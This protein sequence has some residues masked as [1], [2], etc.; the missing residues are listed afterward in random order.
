MPSPDRLV[1]YL[2]LAAADEAQVRRVMPR[3]EDALR[4]ATLPDAGT[5]LL[6]VRKLA[7]GRIAGGATSQTL[8]R[9]IEQRVAEAG[10]QWVDGGATAAEGAAFVSFASVFEARVQLALRLARGDTCS[11]WYW[12]LAVP[13]FRA[14]AGWRDNLRCMAQ[15]LAELPE[16]RSALPAWT[17]RLV[18]A[19]AQ[20]LLSAAVSEAQGLTLLQQAGIAPLANHN[21][22]TAG[23]AANG[24]AAPTRGAAEHSANDAFTHQQ[25]PDNTPH[26]LAALL[27]AGGAHRPV[28]RARPQSPVQ[29]TVLRNGQTNAK[30]AANEEP[31]A[32]TERE[33]CES[34]SD[35]ERIPA[36]LHAPQP[37]TNWA[38]EEPTAREP[39]PYTSEAPAD[40]T[41]PALAEQARRAWRIEHQPPYLAPTACG[42]LLFLLPVLSRLGIASWLEQG[43]RNDGRFV[44]SVLAEAMRRLRVDA[45][46]PAWALV[47]ATFSLPAPIALAPPNWNDALLAAPRPSAIRNDL[48]LA[49]QQ[50][51]SREQQARLWLT[52]ARRWL[53]RGAR[54]GLASLVMRPGF[55]SLTPTHADMHFCL[56]DTDMRVRQLGLDID[57]G[58]LPWFGRVVSFHYDEHLP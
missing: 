29:D 11:A 15:A 21:E 54:I 25:R 39:T 2:R 4:C 43:K 3:L 13:E 56:R 5:R 50:A 52:A 26:W 47:P 27:V 24:I 6:L 33:T 18:E 42:G 55:I 8:S 57:P 23:D 28:S 17:R 32:K 7:L 10:A 9:L 30:T 37:R 34:A 49:L 19:G 16:A 22:P 46:D 20:H 53:R 58:W 38:H 31:M 36:T 48:T 41:P 35:D 45:D 51:A 44:Q 1:H 14:A 40:T 12:P